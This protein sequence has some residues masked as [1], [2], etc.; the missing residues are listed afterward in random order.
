MKRTAGACK[1][2]TVSGC[3]TPNYVTITTFHLLR[4]ERTAT[5]CPLSDH[6]GQR[7]IL[8]CDGLS[9]YDP[10]RTR[11]VR[12]STHLAPVKAESAVV[13]AVANIIQRLKR[14]NQSICAVIVKSFLSIGFTGAKFSSF[15]KPHNSLRCR[16]R[17]FDKFPFC[18]KQ[19]VT[20]RLA[21]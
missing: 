11:S 18:L 7:W 4:A 15:I 19:V 21:L 20:R 14:Y 8:A 9:A 12:R 16:T 17:N 5:F 1:G 3:R 2:G 10:K 6:S 13:H